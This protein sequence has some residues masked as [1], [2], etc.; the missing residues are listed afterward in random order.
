AGKTLTLNTGATL[1]LLA[2]L[3]NDTGI[4]DPPVKI[5]GTL[6][7]ADNAEVTIPALTA[8]TATN[9]I[10]SVISFGTTGKL[11]VEKGA[12]VN[13]GTVPT[14]FV[15]AT[16]A[17]YV[18]DAAGEAIEFTQHH[19]KIIGAVGLGANDII[20]KN[21]TLEIAAGAT[22]SIANG[23]KLTLNAEGQGVGASLV[24]PGKL[25][26]HKT[27]IVGGIYGG[28]QVTSGSGAAN[29]TIAAAAAAS[30]ITA[31]VPTVSLVA[32]GPGAVITQVGGAPNA[33]TITC[34]S[35]V[36]TEGVI[37]LASDGKLVLQGTATTAP[38][39]LLPA[40]GMIKIGT[41]AA[42]ANVA[43]GALALTNATVGASLTGKTAAQGA[44][45]LTQIIGAASTNTIT[46]TTTPG[47][48]VTITANI[49]ATGT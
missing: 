33:L 24:G 30:T 32:K 5:Y 21:D 47:D 4:T 41:G 1:S 38:G 44:S 8:F 20:P 26:A 14:A 18:L 46:G 49:P 13:T 43:A 11:R 2:A 35:A 37:N 27:E 31:S 25:I 16:S 17:P 42:T 40:N 10:S 48:D 9:D 19:R 29:V 15:A 28:W 3:A 39:I 7:V 45:V 6:V 34:T 22:L 23:F 12:T 36:S